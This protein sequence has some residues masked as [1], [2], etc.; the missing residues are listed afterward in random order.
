[1]VREVCGSQGG[2]SGVGGKWTM[3]DFSID[4]I[5]MGSMVCDAKEMVIENAMLCVLRYETRSPVNVCAVSALYSQ[6]ELMSVVF[7]QVL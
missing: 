5:W 3:S 4:L 1:V 6:L 2:I 7:P